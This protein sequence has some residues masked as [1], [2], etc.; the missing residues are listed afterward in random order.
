MLLEA[1]RAEYAAQLP[2]KIVAIEQAWQA[3]RR[4]VWDAGVW[5][6]LQHSLHTLAGSSGTYGFLSL[7]QNARAA[8]NYIASIRE[9]AGP[10]TPAQYDQVRTLIEALHPWKTEAKGTGIDLG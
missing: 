1:L 8:E 6:H 4:D 2:G 3:V 9:C 5:D 10:P 7:S